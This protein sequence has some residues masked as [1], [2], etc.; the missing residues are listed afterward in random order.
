MGCSASHRKDIQE[1]NEFFREAM[2]FKKKKYKR[3]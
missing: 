2:G 1:K 3:A